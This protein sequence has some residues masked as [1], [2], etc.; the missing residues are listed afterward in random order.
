MKYDPG[1]IDQGAMDKG[2]MNCAQPRPRKCIAENPG[3]WAED[4]ENPGFVQGRT[5]WLAG[6]R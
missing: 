1:I 6:G 3:E 2:A 5:S 4:E